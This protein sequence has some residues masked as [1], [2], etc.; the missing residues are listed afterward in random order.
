VAR[1]R[2]TLVDAVTP[3]R[4]RN[5]VNKLLDAADAGEPWAVKEVLDRTLGRPMQGLALV[6]LTQS[7]EAD[8]LPV[9]DAEL[10][11]SLRFEVWCRRGWDP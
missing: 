8:A 9:S 7:E 1:W 5:I 11:H 10:L 4:V 2:Q 6:A 3:E